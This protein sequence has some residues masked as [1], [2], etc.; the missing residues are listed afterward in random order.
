ML[1]S[2]ELQAFRDEV[3]RF[4]ADE[5]PVHLRAKVLHNQ[6]LEKADYIAWQRALDRKGWFA[7]HWPVEHGG[8]GWSALKRWIF[9]EEL[10]AAGAPWLIPFGISYVGPVIYTFGNEAQK[11]THLGPIR[12]SEIWWAQGYSEPGAGSDLASLS[13]RAV[14]D[15]DHYRVTGQK[16]WISYA[17]WADKMFLLARTSTEGKPQDGIS[18]LLLDMEMPG[19]VVRPIPTI[20]RYHHVNEIF[21]DDV[22]VPVANLVG[23]ENRGWTQAKFLLDRERLLTAEVG[24]AKRLLQRLLGLARMTPSGSGSLAGDR[25]WRLKFAEIYSETLALEATCLDLLTE[26]QNGRD[27][28]P[29][30][31]MLK[32]VGSELL[33][34]INGMTIDVLGRH[35][36][37]YD[38]SGL[39][40]DGPMTGPA[41]FAGSVREYL[42]SRVLSIYGGSNEIQRNIIARGVLGLGR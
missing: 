40:A 3:R 12:R 4:C 33:Q 6:K 38:T 32:I 21:L 14:R 22:K 7:G 25:H 27:P 20:D 39:S 13:T 36:L 8:L 41:Q 5:L 35:G 31:S 17:H 37:A 15:G 16:I 30:A 9:E 18:F 24:K 29:V 10:Y 42:Y 11:R 26:A 23:A 1:L 34:R 28:G 2:F 19:I